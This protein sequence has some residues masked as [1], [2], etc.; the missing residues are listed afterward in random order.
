M[1]RRH[2]NSEP[3]QSATGVE[4]TRQ[5]AFRFALDPHREREAQLWCHAGAARYA[6]NK[7]LGWVKHGLTCR[8]WERE[9]GGEP[10]TEVPWTKFSLINAFNAWKHAK[11][12]DPLDG[13]RG[14]TWKDEV[15]QDVFEC[16]MVDL[17]QALASWADSRSGKRKGRRVGFPKHKAKKRATPS[18][19]LRNRARRGEV[20]AIRIVDSKHVKVPGLGVVR[21]HGSNRQLRGLLDTGRAHLYSATFRY[22][23][24]RWW[25]TLSGVA[26][27][28]HPARQSRK[29]RHPHPAGIDLGVRTLAVCADDTGEPVK[30]WEGVNALEGAQ[31][32]LRRANRRLARTKSGSSGRRDAAQRVGRLHRRVA[33]L[34]RDALH[35]LTHWAASNLA[36]VTVEDLNV[37]GMLANRRLARRLSDASLAELRRQLTYKARW[38]GTTLHE[39]DR[40]YASSKICSACGQKN[41][42]LDLGDVTWT[43]PHPLCHMT[44]N[45]DHNAA[46]NLARWPRQQYP[47]PARGSPDPPSRVEPPGRRGLPVEPTSAGPDPRSGWNSG[48]RTRNEP[49]PRGLRIERGTSRPDHPWAKGTR[50]SREIG[51][52]PSFRLVVRIAGERLGLDLVDVAHPVAVGV[53]RFDGGEVAHGGA[54]IGAV[55]VHVLLAAR[56]LGVAGHTGVELRTPHVVLGVELALKLRR[57]LRGWAHHREADGTDHRGQQSNCSGHSRHAHMCWPPWRCG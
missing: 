49:S 53:L 34:R 57:A 31:R 2:A 43:C 27:V 44:H 23:Q 36:E 3:L 16:A 32:Q 50:C 40:F 46:V 4:R 37:A 17:G 12:A 41:D 15:C 18:F 11:A 26:A 29:A 28:F 45:R 9:L 55:G 21:H 24:G 56:L 20:Q 1:P 42:A 30:C 13:S 6:W 38:Y 51:Y 8:E 47:P 10:W 52:R 14:L 22:E 35:Q 54:E 39:A 25:V 33:H 7:A 48:R 5:V 19:R